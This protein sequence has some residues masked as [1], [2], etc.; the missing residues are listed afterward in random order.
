MKVVRKA[1]YHNAK[2]VVR[3]SKR[4]RLTSNAARIAKRYGVRVRDY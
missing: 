1:K 3:K 4:T 2:P